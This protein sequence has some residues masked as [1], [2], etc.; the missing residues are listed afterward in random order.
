VRNEKPILF[1]DDMIRAI[2]EGRKTQTRRV[3]KSPAKNMQASGA[4]VIKHRAP[5]D[6]WYGDHVWSMR[7]SS[8]VWGDYTHE[9]FL[10]MCPYGKPGDRLWVRETWCAVDDTDLNGERW[11]DYRA[12]P[13]YSA[14][15]PAGWEN[16]PDSPEAL[17]WRPSIHMPRWAS[18]ITLE[19]TDVRVER[20]QDISE[21]DAIAEGAQH[22]PD[23]P[24]MSPYGQ[25]CRWSM[26]QPESV[27]QCLSSARWA[28]ANYFCK[29]AGNAPKGLHDEKPWEANPWVWVIE[30]KR[31]D[32]EVKAA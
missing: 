20:L 3:V 28:F 22:F 9:R 12:T 10:S 4:E 30:F 5:G 18:R 11:V 23:L 19:I 13:R 27:Y 6:K 25:D 29:L 26:E 15:H 1:K 24:G 8:G 16:A 2:L 17:K 32:Q 7:G 31:I 14:E 21:E